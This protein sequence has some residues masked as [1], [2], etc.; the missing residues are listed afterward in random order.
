M[1]EINRFPVLS[2]E[3]EFSLAVRLVKYNDME[4]ATKL[5]VSNL[6]FVVKIA[7]EYRNY[8]LKL[9]DLVQEGNI[10]L[11]HAV[12]KFDPYK[13]YRLISYAVWWIRA[14]MQN[15]IIK[16]WSLVKIGT[17]QTQRKLFFKLAEAK[18]KLEGLSEK[19]PEFA[20]IAESIGV[21]PEEIEE[22]DRRLGGRD[23]SLDAQVTDDGVA[24]HLDQLIYEGES[25]ET[26]LIRQEE[27]AL[28]RR[29]IAGALA[30]LNEK[31]SFIIKN[32][33][34]AEDPMTLQAIGNY[35]RITRERARQIEK[36]AV[37]KLALAIPYLGSETKLIEG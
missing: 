18:K 10:G 8:G 21:R 2:A 11:M 6:R 9:S 33:I 17:T 28:V 14:Y 36:Q 30:K 27:M 35:Y 25:Q 20:E 34:M 37:K 19:R 22:M 13:G 12:K 3:E 32:R 23:L 5:V 7:H 1:S 26:E 29:H 4:A 31:E 16:S 15:Y 24:T